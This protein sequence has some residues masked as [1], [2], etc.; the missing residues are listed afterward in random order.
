MEI[1]DLNVTIIKE[2]RIYK[3]LTNLDKIKN[4]IPCI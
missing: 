1:L 2:E 3:K 4:L